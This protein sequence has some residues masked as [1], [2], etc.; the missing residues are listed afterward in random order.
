MALCGV[1]IAGTSGQ[2]LLQAWVQRPHGL[3]AYSLKG[4]GNPVMV[5]FEGTLNYLWP[6]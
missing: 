1:H 2:L 4:D 3:I 5:V 6:H